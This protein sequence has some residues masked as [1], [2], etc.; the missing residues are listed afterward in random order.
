MGSRTWI[1]VHCQNWVSGTIRDETPEVRCAW[2]DLLALVGNGQH[3]DTGELKLQNGIGY[4]DVQ[5]AD[6]LQIDKT[7]WVNAKQRFI[8]TERIT[9]TPK[10]EITVLK[11]TK[12]QSDYTRTKQYRKPVI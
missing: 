3:S 4:A 9:V 11:W 12:Y 5:I 10:N 2:I 7:L 1:K 8:T 6:I